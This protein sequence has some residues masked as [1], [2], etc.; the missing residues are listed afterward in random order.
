MKLTIK[1]YGESLSLRDGMVNSHID[2]AIDPREIEGN[3]LDFL[4][5]KGKPVKIV[6]EVISYEEMCG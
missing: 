1:G 5:F 4:Q 2:I 6:I 3:I